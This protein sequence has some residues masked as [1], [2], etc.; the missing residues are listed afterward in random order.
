[1]AKLITR[2]EYLRQLIQNKDVDL[3]KMMCKFD[4]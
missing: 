2:T 1:M 4:Y 3:I